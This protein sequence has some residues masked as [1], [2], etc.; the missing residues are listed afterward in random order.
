MDGRRPRST[1]HPAPDHDAW[2]RRHTAR[3]WNGYQ[4]QSRE[5]LSDTSEQWLPPGVFDAP[6]EQ[7]PDSTS[8]PVSAR[9]RARRRAPSRRGRWA[10]QVAVLLPLALASS[11]W[12]AF[13]NPETPE[14]GWFPDGYRV[15]LGSDQ[16]STR[17]PEPTPSDTNVTATPSASQTAKQTPRGKGGTDPR[18]DGAPGRPTPLPD[19]TNGPD[20]PAPSEPAPP[21]PDPVPRETDAPQPQPTVSRAPKPLPSTTPTPG[22][23]DGQEIPLPRLPLPL[24][25]PT[26]LPLPLPFLAPADSSAST[27]SFPLFTLF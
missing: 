19:K 4:G 17:E 8:P 13:G 1:Q 23:P 22:A 27:S 6:A 24:P 3:T 2:N 14:G 10:R 21:A 18:G 11:S 12:A 26:S 25:L 20:E 9:H 16:T 7:R 15:A 5:V